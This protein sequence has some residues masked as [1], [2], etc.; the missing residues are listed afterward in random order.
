MLLKLGCM[1]KLA[2]V[3]EI[4]RSICIGKKISNLNCFIT[5]RGYQENYTS[6]SRGVVVVLI[7]VVAVVGHPCVYYRM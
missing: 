4:H 1:Q 2:K 6:T 7:V 5:Q 3:P